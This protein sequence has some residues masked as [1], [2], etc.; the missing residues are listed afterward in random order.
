MN[1]TQITRMAHAL[2]DRLYVT[3]ALDSSSDV[4]G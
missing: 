4:V 1:L 2:S 3:D